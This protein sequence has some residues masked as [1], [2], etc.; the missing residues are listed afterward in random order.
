MTYAATE[1]IKFEPESV[2]NLATPRPGEWCLWTFVTKHGREYYSGAWYEWGGEPHVKTEYGWSA[3]LRG[4]YFAR[5][6]KLAGEP[7]GPADSTTD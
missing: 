7:S 5:V 3:P 4:A 6:N 2:A 1:W